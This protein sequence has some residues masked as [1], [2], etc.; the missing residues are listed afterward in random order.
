MVLFSTLISAMLNNT[1]SAKSEKKSLIFEIIE[2]GINV[3][4][5]KYCFILNMLKK[6]KSLVGT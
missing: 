6:E 5:G 4:S 3:S 1:T 2:N